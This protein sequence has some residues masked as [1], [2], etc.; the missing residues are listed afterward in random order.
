MEIVY[1]LYWKVWALFVFIGLTTWPVLFGGVIAYYLFK[2]NHKMISGMV[3]GF[4]LLLYLI[5]IPWIDDDKVNPKFRRYG[6]NEDMTTLVW[7]RYVVFE[8][9]ERYR[10]RTQ[11]ITK[12]NHGTKY[13]RFKLLS[14]NPPKHFRVKLQHIQT[15]RVYE[16][17]VSKHCDQWRDNEVGDEYNIA[18]ARYSYSN[19]PETVL[20]EF[21]GLK[22]S[23]C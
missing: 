16:I 19:K 13:E 22:D 14:L 11:P 7:T 4:T 17:G 5:Y 6:H 21:Q 2:S 3:A 15:G 12:T 8:N 23:F 9:R 10:I 20:F 1:M 18:V